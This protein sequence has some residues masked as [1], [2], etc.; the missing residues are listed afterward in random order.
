MV[1]EGVFRVKDASYGLAFLPAG[2]HGWGQDIRREMWSPMYGFKA[3]RTVLRFGA[4]VPLPAE[5]AVLLIAL[6][7]THRRA[8]SFTRVE[9]PLN[10]EI[11]QYK[12]SAD[13]CDYS[14]I[15]G[16]GENSNSWR[17]GL[18]SSDAKYV[19]HKREPGT[20]RE[21]LILGSGTYARVDGGPKLR[22]SHTVAWA[23]LVVNESGQTVSSSDGSAVFE[24]TVSEPPSNKASVIAGEI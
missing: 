16:S 11:P 9:N 24:Q 12:Y 10:S 8:E 6:E 21:R 22:S 14:F 18:L 7:G 13:G 2:G 19:C 17:K 20:G 4:D 5:F 3:P 15:F 1:E 23:E